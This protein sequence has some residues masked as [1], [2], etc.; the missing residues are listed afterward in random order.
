MP[1]IEAPSNF[2]LGRYF[3]P[4]TKHLTDEVVYY[5][6]RDLT[7]HMVVVGMTGSGKTGLCITILEEAALDGIPAIIIDPKG[8]ITNLLLAFPDLQAQ[9]FLPWINMDDAHRAGLSAPVRMNMAGE[10]FPSYCPKRGRGF[11]PSD[12]WT[13]TVKA[14]CC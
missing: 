2:Y 13:A 5:E 8:D 3:D 11:I 12:D 10:S 6:S 9:S 14:W 7:T 1:F 4:E